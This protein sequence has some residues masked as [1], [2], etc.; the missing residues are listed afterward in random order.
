MIFFIFYNFHDDTLGRSD[1]AGECLGLQVSSLH[2]IF[3][4][5]LD[6]THGTYDYSRVV[7]FIL[8]LIV[9]NKLDNLCHHDL[10]LAAFLFPRKYLVLFIYQLLLLF[11]LIFL[12][13]SLIFP[14]LSALHLVEVN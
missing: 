3:Q 6:N 10:K 5:C 14:A 2:Q 13:A 4:N 1:L 7:L 11:E 12:A 9:Q 8:L